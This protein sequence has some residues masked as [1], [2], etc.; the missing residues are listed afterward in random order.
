MSKILRQAHYPKLYGACISL[1]NLE[2]GSGDYRRVRTGLLH[3]AVC[4]ANSCPEPAKVHEGTTGASLVLRLNVANTPEKRLIHQ[5]QS[6]AVYFIT[7]ES[8]GQDKFPLS[9]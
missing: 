5:T 2:C 9:V 4:E 6:R 1:V 8:R 7:T 3:K